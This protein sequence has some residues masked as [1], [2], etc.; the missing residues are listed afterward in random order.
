[1]T[2]ASDDGRKDGTWRVIAGK[3]GLAHAGAI[4]A[5]QSSNLVVAHFHWISL[6]WSLMYRTVP[7]HRLKPHVDMRPSCV[8]L[9]IGREPGLAPRR[10]APRSIRIASRTDRVP[11]A[12]GSRIWRTV[13][14]IGS[15]SLGCENRPRR[16]A[17]VTA[18][19]QAAAAAMAAAA[20]AGS[21]GARFVCTKSCTWVRR[22]LLI[23]HC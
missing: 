9:Y 12:T 1:V 3:S 20:D 15:R 10:A 8:S 7:T 5:D 13:G 14:Q 11:P 23:T 4:V 22:R 19:E 16:C 17:P 18:I 21:E 6:I 2:W